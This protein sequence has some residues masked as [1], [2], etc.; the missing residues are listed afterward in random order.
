[1]DL[2]LHLSLGRSLV[3]RSTITHKEVDKMTKVTTTCRS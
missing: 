3:F 2:H 1:M